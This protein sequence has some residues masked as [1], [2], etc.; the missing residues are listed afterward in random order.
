MA[1]SAGSTIT[2]PVRL[3]RR[4]RAA[5]RWVRSRCFD[6]RTGRPSAAPV[7][8]VELESSSTTDAHVRPLTVGRVAVVFTGGT[9]SM[10]LDRAREGGPGAA[11]RRHPRPDARARRDRRRRADRLGLDPRVAPVARPA[12]GD[13]PHRSRDALARPEIDGAVV[14]QGTDTIEETAFAWD[15]LIAVRQ[16]G[17]RHRRDA[18]RRRGGLRGPG[19]L[20]AAVAV[21]ASRRRAR[22]GHAGGDGDGAILPADDARKMHTRRRSTRSGRRTSGRSGQVD[23]GRRGA[24]GAGGAPGARPLPAIPAARV[25][26]GASSCRRGSARTAT[27]SV[28]GCGLGAGRDRGGRDR[29]R[30]TRI[31]T[32]SRRR[33]TRWRQAC[34]W[35]SS[36]PG[37]VGARLGGYGFPGGGRPGWLRVRCRPAGWVPPRHGS[38]WRSGSGRLGCAARGSRRSSRDDAHRIRG[39]SSSADES[40]RCPVRRASAGKV[41][42]A[43]DRGVVVAAGRPATSTRLPGPGL[44]AGRSPTRRW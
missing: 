20:R 19:N 33:A 11:R 28:P 6:V 7:E 17:R 27:C 30:A 43:I 14:V 5:T 39:A 23:G 40:P 29:R 12:A 35:C 3:T 38:R 31:R 18:Q 10:R 24:V 25:G 4:P 8:P 26:A 22:A 41:A 9:I 36:R 37:A 13:R 1:V 42:I 34:R 21:A 44:A 15:L 16:A 32:C 2:R